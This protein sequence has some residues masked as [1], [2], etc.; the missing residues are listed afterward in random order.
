MRCS[1][2]SNDNTNWSRGASTATWIER[3]IGRAGITRDSDPGEGRAA[4]RLG[5]RC[6]RTIGRRLDESCTRRVALSLTLLGRQVI[7]NV[8]Y[9]VRRLVWPRSLVSPTQLDRVTPV[10]RFVAVSDE[11][12]IDEIPDAGD[13][14]VD[15]EV[16]EVARPTHR[17]KATQ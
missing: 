2:G 17:M 16:L 15:V 8:R 11:Q 13:D 1:G 5:S 14:P 4:A 9:G 12:F 6:T 7:A 3:L 10:R